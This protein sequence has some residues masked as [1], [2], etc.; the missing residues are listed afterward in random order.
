MAWD[1]QEKSGD[2]VGGG[3]DYDENNLTY[4]ENID[5]ESTLSVLYDS[6]GVGAYSWTNLTKN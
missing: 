5:P 1:L 4:N 2:P 3:W 6:L